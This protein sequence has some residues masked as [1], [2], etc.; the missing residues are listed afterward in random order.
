MNYHANTLND[1]LYNT[2]Q[3]LNILLD[4][5]GYKILYTV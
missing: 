5:K 1:A 4:E 3:Y 2:G